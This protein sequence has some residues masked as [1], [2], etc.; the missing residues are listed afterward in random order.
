MST[1]LTRN[2]PVDDV[3]VRVT[4]RP[5]WRPP[6]GDRVRRLV[7][8]SAS[9]VGTNVV[10]SV[11]GLGFWAIAARTLDA[12]AVGVAGAAVS[13][14]MMVGALGSLGLGTLLIARLPAEPQGSR[15]RLV[16]SCLLLAAGASAVL[17]LLTV[18]PA[19][20]LLGMTGLRPLVDTPADVAL[21]AGSTALTA[22]TMVLDQ[23]VLV[24]G[25]GALQLRRNLVASVVKIVAL[26]AVTGAGGR[27]GLV[28]LAAWTAGNVVSL[29]LVSHW[30]R[31]G[32]ALQDRGPLVDRRSLHGLGRDALSHHALN[33]G[34]QAPVQLL[35]VVVTVMVSA[36]DN[37]YFNGALLVTGFVFTLPF[38]LSVGLFAVAE[39]D[40]REVL[41]R[42]RWTVPFGL[43]VSLAADV[44]LYP[45]ADVVLRVFGDAYAHESAGVLRVLVLA[46][47]AFVIKD[48]F[49]ALRRVQNRTAGAAVLVA[50]FSAAELAAAAAGAR[51]GGTLGLSW[52]WV[53]TVGLEA[54]VFLA[55]L[56]RGVRG[57]P[58]GTLTMAPP[59]LPQGIALEPPGL[60][61]APATRPSPGGTPE[62]EPWSQVVG[63]SEGTGSR[64]AAARHAAPRAE[65]VGRDRL[66]PTLLI[67]SAGLLLMAL[68]ATAARTAS[69]RPSLD[70]LYAVGLAV[71]FLPP[72]ARIAYRGTPRRER[73][74]LA[75]ALPAALQLS[76]T[77]LHP[78]FFAYHDEMIHANTLRV[79]GATHHLFTQ[80][81]LLPVSSYYPGLEVVTDGVVQVSGAS[82]FVSA[83][84][85]LVLARV[86]LATAFLALVLSITGSARAASVAAVVYTCNPQLI[87][88]NAQFSYQTLA[89][90]LA[91]LAVHLV[92]SR[93]RTGPAGVLGAAATAVAV[94]F[95]HHLTSMLLVGALGAWTGAELLLH[96]RRNRGE[97]RDLALVTGVGL[98]AVVGATTVPGNPVAGYLQ[99]IARTVQGGVDGLA[100]G[101]PAKA[102]FT[103][104]A[105]AAS[106]PWEQLLMVFAVTAVALAL[107]PAWL[108][109]RTWWTRR[110]PLALGLVLLSLLYPLI[111]AGHLTRDTAE[112]GDRS[113]GFVFLGIAFVV[114]WAVHDRIG[115]GVRAALVATAATGVF[116][117][118]VVLGAG[119]VGSQLPG[120]Y[121]VSADARSIDADSLAAARWT[122]ASLP[123][124]SRVYADR[125]SGLLAA[126][127]GGQ[128]TV[129]HVSSDVDA[130]RLILDPRFTPEDVAVAR[131]AGIRYVV[132]DQRDAQSLPHEG[133]YIESGEFGQAGRTEPVP[134]AAL[135]KLAAVP[136]V[137]RIYD[138]GSVVV[139]DVEGMLRER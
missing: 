110:E 74:A 10:T 28:I 31:G 77:I 34:L 15:R 72:A 92:R 40:E 9:L 95:T 100:G 12:D 5:S 49:V 8:V 43:V 46:G 117:G 37:G 30:T 131:A 18:W 50:A 98:A 125:V 105:G 11:L 23:A 25:V 133:V 38:A 27:G 108:R 85:V 64:V 21:L 87:F 29:P 81:P 62:P 86:V 83:S 114:G 22:V 109:A 61:A 66:A 121:Q 78:T 7:G 58:A 94:A 63:R 90:P 39:G 115:G 106:L 47:L 13:M 134:R 126:A 107:P 73:L 103:D 88:F 111:P 104:P 14:M 123:P 35:P 19:V 51:W 113:A 89:L 67:L 82:P 119:P 16:R 79:I 130:S 80:N 127:I 124:E 42:L 136:G 2:R 91:V 20:E 57:R 33:L 138:N 102:A 3:E 75:V 54:G 139:Y 120:P 93:G 69:P 32:R 26:V 65:L 17:S 135:V 118:N 137:R 53:A 4:A 48:H 70:V 101:R 41:G 128:H 60:P 122:A 96:G 99:A 59:T 71:V 76:R 52:A 45:C 112:V 132:V 6:G 55:L 1:P 24:L 56:V 84:L 97:V 36:R 44:V 129:R 68:A 116:V